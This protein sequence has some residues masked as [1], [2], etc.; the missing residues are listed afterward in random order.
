[1]TDPYVRAPPPKLTALLD[2]RLQAVQSHLPC[3]AILAPQPPNPT[4]TTR[5][6]T[7]GTRNTVTK[8][9]RSTLPRLHPQ[10]RRLITSTSLRS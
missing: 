7:P 6:K 9:C 2:P 1:M 4:T 3:P 5:I 8:I 10:N